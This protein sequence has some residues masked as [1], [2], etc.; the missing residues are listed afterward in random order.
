[1]S[2]ADV[3]YA[4]Q[5]DL[6]AVVYLVED[7]ADGP[8]RSA[9]CEVIETTRG[10]RAFTGWELGDE[11]VTSLEVP[12]DGRRVECLVASPSFAPA[13]LVPPQVEWKLGRWLVVD[14]ETTGLGPDAEIVEL[15]AVVMQGGEVVERRNVLIKPRRP[16][17]LEV[18]KIHGIYDRHVA[19][20][21]GLHDPHP[22]TARSAAEGLCAMAADAHA[23]VGYNNISFDQPLLERLIPAWS[24]A[25][26]GLP[27]LD[28]LVVVRLPGVDQRG[29]TKGRHKLTA[30]ADWLRLTAP[31][32]GMTV[33][34]HRAAWDCVLAGRI[35]WHLRQHL[36]D[37][38]TAAHKVCAGEGAKQKAE[39]DAYWASRGGR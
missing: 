29:R 31:V 32:E 30:V 37:D 1:M 20:A 36:P 28:A 9:W 15:G 18:S 2:Q 3:I 8:S 7:T 10:Q 24:E 17:P 33:Q 22:T 38:A 12:D 26:A 11:V 14:T 35:L 16:I 4:D 25:C 27:L 21:Q 13:P 23:I 6:H 5:V 19:H 39:L 34:A